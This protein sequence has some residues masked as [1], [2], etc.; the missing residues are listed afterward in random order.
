MIIMLHNVGGLSTL[1]RE[2]EVK[3]KTSNPT[4]LSGSQNAHF[5]GYELIIFSYEKTFI[6]CYSL[7]TVDKVIGTV[8]KRLKYGVIFT[9]QTD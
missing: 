9:I 6:I 7:R 4:C 5:P 8:S 1:Q 3:I 2:K